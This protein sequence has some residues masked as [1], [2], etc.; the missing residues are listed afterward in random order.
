MPPLAP[1][2]G[3]LRRILSV[4]ASVAAYV[5]MLFATALTQ[6]LVAWYVDPSRP[7]KNGVPQSSDLGI[8]V[9]LATLALQAL[10]FW[11]HRLPWFMVGGGAVIALVFSLD[12]TL[13]LLGMSE[14]IARRDRRQWHL[15]VGL[16]AAITTAVVVRNIV[17]QRGIAAMT[18]THA[19]SLALMHALIGV[20]AFA[21]AFALGW[22]R[23]TRRQVEVAD[24]RVEQVEQ[25]A[26]DLN[27][28]LAQRAER[29]RLAREIHDALAHR[30]SLVSLHSGALEDAARSGD[31]AVAEAA[32]VV[33]GNAHRSLEDLRDLIGALRDPRPAGPVE[34][35]VQI[36]R[37]GM[38]DV[39][40]VIDSTMAAGISVNAF[41]ML[42]EPEAAGELLNRAVFRIVQE[43]LTN[44]VKHAPG[45]SVGVDLRASPPQGVSLLIRNRITADASDVPG[46]GSGLVGMR[47]RVGALGGQFSAGPTG[48][49][50]F[51]VR[52][53]LPWR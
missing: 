30:L 42:A 7:G 28:Q 14:V 35:P 41:V 24:A 50:W 47:E 32:R 27:L 16:G 4:L 6:P 31:G 2:T 17:V 13:A 40:D 11:R 53:Q 23:R 10:V 29:E 9:V 48:D 5:V 8:M 38:A 52:V 25:Q 43:A 37:Y 21:I 19:P 26:E 45:S 22:Q 39:A 49:G 18:T 34:E 46:S 3:R 15:A 20:S 12:A 51:Q 33:R 44:V 36:P 1:G